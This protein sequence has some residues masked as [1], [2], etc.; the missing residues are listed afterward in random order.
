MQRPANTRPS[1]AAISCGASSNT[2][3]GKTNAQASPKIP[4]V[5]VELPPAALP[6]GGSIVYQSSTRS[7]NCSCRTKNTRGRLATWISGKKLTGTE[8]GRGDRGESQLP[9]DRPGAVQPLTKTL[10]K[11]LSMSRQ[12]ERHCRRFDA[13]D[14]ELNQYDEAAQLCRRSSPRLRPTRK[15]AQPARAIYIQGDKRTGH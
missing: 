13:S 5:A 1:V 8:T 7:R 9:Y 12:A 3:H 11:A 4:Q 15:L 14:F 10:K 2:T 6:N